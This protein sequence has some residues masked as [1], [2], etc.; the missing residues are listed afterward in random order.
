MISALILTVFGCGEIQELESSTVH[1]LSGCLFGESLGV[2]EVSAAEE[3]TG[4]GVERVDANEGTWSNSDNSV[5]VFFDAHSVTDTQGSFEGECQPGILY[6]GDG[7]LLHNGHE[8]FAAEWATLSALGTDRWL[9]M[10][11][12]H[13]EVQN[14]V[15]CHT[16]AQMDISTGDGPW[17]VG[18]G[19]V[20]YHC[21]AE[22]GS[23]A[24]T[25]VHALEQAGPNFSW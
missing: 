12:A 8:L 1:P 17:A 4:L 2:G 14:G 9:S 3:A 7:Q 22:V 13:E 21:T 24:A 23:D 11:S 10:A 19:F 16:F 6:F 20:Q 5:A 18:G 25:Q 15:F